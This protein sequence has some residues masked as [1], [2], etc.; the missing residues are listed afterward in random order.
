M[1]AKA[2]RRKMDNLW[3]HFQHIF[4]QQLY[5]VRIWKVFNQMQLKKFL[6][7]E[8]GAVTVDWVVLTASTIG[9]GGAAMMSVGGGA[10]SLSDSIQASL[11]NSRL[12][13]GASVEVFADDF[14]DGL[15]GNWI[16]TTFNGG[17]P[18]SS[19]EVVNGQLV[20]RSDAGNDFMALDMGNRADLTNYTIS[21]DIYAA[22]PYNNGVGIVFGYED[23]SNFYKVA[24]VDYGAGYSHFADHKDFSLVQ[25][26][27]GVSTQL[28]V[29]EGQDLPDNFNLSVDVSA[30]TSI[31]V[32]VDG[33]ELMNVAM[34]GTPQ[35]QTIGLYTYDN[36]NGIS[37][38]NVVVTDNVF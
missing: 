1:Y 14:S 10:T 18:R 4:A 24:W 22:G 36:D 3:A 6:R 27:D 17:V 31:S 33:S 35:I 2:E 34:G 29:L 37:Y 26:V 20:E 19:W 25:V 38:D 5:G 16:T 32:S 21:T 11:T 7:S 30:G 15:N 13:Y 12:G 9:L 28:A 23:A 8:T